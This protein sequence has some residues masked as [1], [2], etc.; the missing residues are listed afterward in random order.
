[1]WATSALPWNGR[2]P[3]VGGGREAVANVAH[4]IDVLK[5]CK[6]PVCQKKSEKKRSDVEFRQESAYDSN[7][8]SIRG[9]TRTSHNLGLSKI[10][11]QTTLNRG[12]RRICR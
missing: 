11:A 7:D 6:T 3:A 2:L 10:N 8:I 1:M 4:G 5:N 9:C 12:V